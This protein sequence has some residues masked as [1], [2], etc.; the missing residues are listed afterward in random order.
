MK[1]FREIC[2]GI[3]AGS[4]PL[5]REVLDMKN[6]YGI[7]TLVDLTQ[8]ERSAVKNACAKNGI[9]YIKNP[10]PYEFSDSQIKH[11]SSV[12]LKANRP[13][14]FHCFHGRDRTGE[15]EKE[16]HREIYGK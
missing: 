13:L 16:I 9:E 10:V 3:Y 5:A 11:A 2:T 15:V 14:F 1:R 4:L 12:I 6:K 7:V 8:R